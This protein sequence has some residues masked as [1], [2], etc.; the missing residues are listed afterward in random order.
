MANEQKM[1]QAV[2]SAEKTAQSTTDRMARAAHDAIDSL[3]TYSSRTE[4]R[5]RDTGKVASERTREYAD[6]VS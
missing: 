5:L 4:Q 6:Q 3:T 1:H 2:S